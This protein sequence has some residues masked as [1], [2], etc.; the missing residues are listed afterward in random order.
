[1]AVKFE[2]FGVLAPIIVLIYGQFA[3]NFLVIY[4]LS[5]FHYN[6]LN[7]WYKNF[8]PAHFSLL[9]IINIIQF[10]K[11]KSIR[12]LKKFYHTNFFFP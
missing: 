9:T 10:L 2:V 4:S 6:R 12:H 3:C 7:Q 11:T 1:M 8:K 5:A